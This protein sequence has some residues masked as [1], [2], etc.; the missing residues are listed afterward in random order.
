MQTRLIWKCSKKK[1]ILM[2]QLKN[3]SSTNMVETNTNNYKEE[4]R[5]PGHDKY[6]EQ[7]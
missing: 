3:H 2:K 5:T 6:K 1:N 7:R 4:P